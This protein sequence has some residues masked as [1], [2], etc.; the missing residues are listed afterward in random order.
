MLNVCARAGPVDAGAKVDG[1]WVASSLEIGAAIRVW[2]S[3]RCSG[4]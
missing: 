1:A 3:W 4:E 2:T